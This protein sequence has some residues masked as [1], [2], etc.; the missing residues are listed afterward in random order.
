MAVLKRDLEMT[1][2]L[3]EFG[4]DPD[5]GIWQKRDATSPYI[6]ARERGYDE[7]T[8]LL[9]AAREKRGAR[10]PNGPTEAVRKCQQAFQSGSEEAIVTVFDQHPELPGRR[11]DDAS[12]GGRTGRVAM[13]EMV[14]RSRRRRQPQLPPR[15]DSA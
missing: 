15:L 9:R 1:R 6:L 4:A 12:S 7:I 10:G 2:L 5:G 8:D 13:D 11:P 14:A 3:L